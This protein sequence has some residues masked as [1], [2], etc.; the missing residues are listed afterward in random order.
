M[1]FNGA[2]SFNQPI[3]DWNTSSVTGM[4]AMFYGASS[5]NQPIGD[6]NTSSV[7]IMHGCFTVPLPL[8]KQSETGIPLRSRY[9]KC[10]TMPPLLIRQSETGTLPRSRVW[11]VCLRCLLFQP[12]DRRLEYF[13]GHGYVWDV[14]QCLLLQPTDRKLEYFLGYRHG[15]N[16]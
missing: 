5:F 15:T 8:T 12:T 11:V 9:V 1:M 2:S 16:V 14:L 3:G 6:W 4:L 7:T 10:F 13:L